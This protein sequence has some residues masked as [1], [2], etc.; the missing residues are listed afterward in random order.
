M[1]T[2][3]LSEAIHG[4]LA[5]MLAYAAFNAMRFVWWQWANQGHGCG[6]YTRETKAAVALTVTW[7]GLCILTTAIWWMLHM[8]NHGGDRDFFSGPYLLI[9]GAAL[10]TWGSVCW[11]H[12][13]RPDNDG[14]TWIVMTV[15]G[16]V[17]GIYFALP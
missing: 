11:A 5:V 8:R 1:I 3:Q 4:I 7:S 16:I 13:T 14:Y 15:I 2:A 12:T 10:A 9:G 6:F 17:V